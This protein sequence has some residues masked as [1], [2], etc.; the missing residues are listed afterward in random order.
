MQQCQVVSILYSKSLWLFP[1][2]PPIACTLIQL[3]HSDFFVGLEPNVFRS[4]S[5]RSR[6]PLSFHIPLYFRSLSFINSWIVYVH[7]YLWNPNPLQVDS[8][9]ANPELWIPGFANVYERGL[10]LTIRRTRRTNRSFIFLQPT[11]DIYFWSS[12]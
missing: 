12:F 6:C 10:A 9:F 1:L 4:M 11:H 5:E 7:S 3:G 8:D 2:Y